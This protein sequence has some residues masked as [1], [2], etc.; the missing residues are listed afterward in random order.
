MRRGVA[1]EGK[2]RRVYGRVDEQ[3]GGGRKQEGKGMTRAM[4]KDF[5]EEVGGGHGEEG[6]GWVDGIEDEEDEGEAKQ[7]VRR[8]SIARRNDGNK[9]G[10]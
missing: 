2:M 7:R 10:E 4:G 9:L 6:C 5:E 1:E 3:S 8:G